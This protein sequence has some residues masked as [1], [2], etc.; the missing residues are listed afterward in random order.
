MKKR[1]NKVYHRKCWTKYF[2]TN[3]SDTII[4]T[5]LT[6]SIVEDHLSERDIA[7]L[8]DVTVITIRRHIRRLHL[9]IVIRGRGGPNNKK[10][11]ANVNKQRDQN[12]ITDHLANMSSMEIA[13]KYNMSYQ[14]VWLVLHDHGF[15]QP[16]DK[17]KIQARI[18]EVL[19]LVRQKKTYRYIAGQTELSVSRIGDIVSKYSL[20]NGHIVKRKNHR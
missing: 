15:T 8:T 1:M 9:P 16:M 7:K 17:E 11:R 12:I 19:I 20:K 10:G 14:S 4:D 18:Q 13:K 5:F 3:T 2:G 6:K